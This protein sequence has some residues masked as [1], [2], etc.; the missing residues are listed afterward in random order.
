VGRCLNCDAELSGPFCAACGQRA[1]PANPSVSEL[2]G[3]AWE[4]LSGYDGR[5]VATFRALPH[6]GRLTTNY[7][8]GR[9]ARYL[10]PVRLYLIVSVLYFVIAAAAPEQAAQSAGQVSGPG[11]M[12]IGITNS[13]EMTDADRVEVMKDLETAPWFVQPLLRSI[14]EDPAGFRAAPL[15]GHAASVLRHAAGLR[16]DRVAVLSQ[17]A[18]SRLAGV[19]RSPP[20]VRLPHLRRL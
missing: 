17:Q 1:V 6:P 18:L 10:P 15:Y 7:I 8:A 3:D 20:R 9:R 4:E 19:C 14:T 11:G 2:A 12:R 13:A 16:G 5:I